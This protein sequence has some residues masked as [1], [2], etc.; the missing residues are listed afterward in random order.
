MFPKCRL[1]KRKNDDN[2]AG[3]FSLGLPPHMLSLKIGSPLLLLRNMNPKQGLCNG[4]L[5]VVKQALN[6]LLK[7]EIM[8][9][10]HAGH[11]AWI[12]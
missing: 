1:C 3:L 5:L 7:V 9:D 11:E 8:N 6:K 4:T 12:P 10:S 2:E